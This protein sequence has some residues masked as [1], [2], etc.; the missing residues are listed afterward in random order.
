LLRGHQPDHEDHEN[1]Q[2]GQ[3]RAPGAMHRRPPGGYGQATDGRR[4]AV[5][6]DAAQPSLIW[7]SPA[8]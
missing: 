2:R 4:A 6:A 8:A 5:L 3:A 1:D 7:R